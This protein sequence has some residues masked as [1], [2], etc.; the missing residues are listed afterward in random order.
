[1][2]LDALSSYLELDDDG[3]D[4]WR[5]R[6]EK[7]REEPRDASLEAPQRVYVNGLRFGG[8]ESAR[9]LRSK[10]KDPREAFCEEWE[11]TVGHAKFFAFVK[12]DPP[13]HLE[14]I[15]RMRRFEQ[16]YELTLPASVFEFFARSGVEDMIFTLQPTNNRLLLPDEWEVLP[17]DERVAL[18]VLDE[19]Q[20]SCFWYLVWNRDEPCLDPPV[21]VGEFFD[22][23]PDEVVDDDDD[24]GAWVEAEKAR[25]ARGTRLTAL[26]FSEFVYDYAVEGAR[27]WIEGGDESELDFSRFDRRNVREAS[28]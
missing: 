10:R 9:V 22:V 19:N 4:A 18:R 23:A 6:L 1:M 12:C 11:N 2:T 25:F 15:E 3:P 14:T 28:T 24:Y 21:Y 7:L 5:A 27:W 20:G 13:V 17:Y 8:P 26:R 16:E